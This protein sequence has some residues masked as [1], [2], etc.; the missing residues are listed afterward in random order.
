[1]LFMNHADHFIPRYL[2][3]NTSG[4]S[5]GRGQ[6]Q[7]G[8]GSKRL[9]SDKI[10]CGEKSDRCLLAGL[11]NDRDLGATAPIGKSSGRGQTQTGWGSK[12]LFSDK[13]AC[14]EKSDRCLLA[15]LRNDR[16]LGATA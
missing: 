9:F 3:C 15:G 6:T 16:D 7:T 4:K 8:W 13:I 14:G 2:Q 5:S 12:R 1:M 11:R 10:A